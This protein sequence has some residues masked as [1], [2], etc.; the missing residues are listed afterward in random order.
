MSGT[1][2]FQ[3]PFLSAGQAQKEFT[4]NE[5]LQ[6]LD[7]VVAPAVEE[8]PRTDPPAVPT[9]GACYIVG[10]SPT[11]DWTGRSQAV[12]GFTSGGWRFI[13]PV[14]GMS[15]FVKADASCATFHQGAWEMGVVRGSTLVLGG[16]QVVGSRLPAI[17]SPSGG[18][19]IDS[20]ARNTLGQ[21]LDALRQH[22]LIE[23]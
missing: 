7:L 21:M 19:T 18:S 20:E 3:L 23:A 10:S 13:D 14:E 1:P 11:G 5:A 15:L 8:G 4:H 16:D 9:L 12:A 17:V 22:G 6:I 2:R